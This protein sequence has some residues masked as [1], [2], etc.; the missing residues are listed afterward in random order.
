MA[1]HGVRYVDVEEDGSRWFLLSHDDD[2][3]S[4]GVEE[5]VRP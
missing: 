2:P 3:Y 4:W 1:A 5:F